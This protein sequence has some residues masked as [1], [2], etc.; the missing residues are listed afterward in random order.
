MGCY[1]DSASG[2]FEGGE[3]GGVVGRDA[4][5]T[6]GGLGELVD[7]ALVDLVGPS[8]AE[9][10]QSQQTAGHGAHGDL[11]VGN[12]EPTGGPPR[13]DVTQG[14]RCKADRQVEGVEAR[15]DEESGQI[16]VGSAQSSGDP[17]RD[18]EHHGG[19]LDAG[20]GPVDHG[21]P[22]FENLVRGDLEQLSSTGFDGDWDLP[23][24]RVLRGCGVVVL[25]L[26][27]N[28]RNKADLAVKTA[29][30]EPIDVLGDRDL[31]VV[32]GPPRAFV[33]YQFGLEQAVL[34]ASAIAIKPEVVE[35]PVEGLPVLRGHQH[36][37]P[38]PLHL[39]RAPAAGAAGGSPG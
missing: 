7:G 12:G 36:D 32:D 15:A 26:E 17:Q 11:R 10:E 28:G 8:L 16:G 37:V 19:V 34:N 3:A 27:L 35:V 29:V 23:R 20:A 2:S 22:A 1:Q 21:A 13:S 5:H 18:S 9:T 14:A 4:E 6:Q 39:G 33:A 30:I 31:Q 24:S 38:E 25:G